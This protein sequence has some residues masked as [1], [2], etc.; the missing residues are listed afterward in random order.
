[1]SLVGLSGEAAEAFLR[2]QTRGRLPRVGRVRL[3]TLLDE[4]GRG[5]DEV[6][7]SRSG[8]EAWT[9]SCHGSPAVLAHLLS[10]ARR[11]GAAPSR[12]AGPGQGPGRTEREAAHL[13]PLCRTEAA[14]RLVLRQMNGA[15]PEEVGRLLLL[16][17]DA[18]ACERRLAE[19]LQ[20]SRWGR[21]LAS[22]PR[23]ALLGPPNVGKSSLLNALCGRGRALVSAEAG[24]TRDAVEVEGE[25]EGLWVCFVDTAGQRETEAAVEAAGIAQAGREAARADL[26]VWVGEAV[27]HEPGGS[28]I[29]GLRVWNKSDLL[30]PS[31][32]V[33]TGRAGHWVSALSGAG[34]DALRQGIRAC[35][36]GEEPS[37]A[38]PL[39]PRQAG[40]VE[41]A[42]RALRAGN[43]QK[44]RSLLQALDG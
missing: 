13:L 3:V 44:Y 37:G 12:F 19:L 14:C 1:L 10:L 11:A 41:G 35:L 18:E 26:K 28:P 39:L 25:V 43:F 20:G 33:N 22:P 27:G 32:P 17:E 8:P 34:L 16:W 42:R 30:T 9:L 4:A 40:L 2:E 6:L 7:L 23:V 31:G 5:L 21:A 29:Q 24:T 15:W 38:C 36:V